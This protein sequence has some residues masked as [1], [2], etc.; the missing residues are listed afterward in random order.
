MSLK[1]YLNLNNKKTRKV[2][3]VSMLSAMAALNTGFTNVYL[4]SEL[5]Q[6]TIVAD[7]ETVTLHTNR[8]SPH[9][10]L[11]RAGVKLSAGDEYELNK[12]DNQNV[13]INVYRAVPV[14]IEYQG[15]KKEVLTS[16]QTVEEA[17]QEAGYDLETIEAAPGLDTKIRANLN[18][19]I[20]DSA[21]KLEAL[22]LE[23]EEQAR[24]IETSR[25]MTRYS[26]VMEMEATAY[27]PT[28][29]GGNGITA[30]GLPAQYGVVAVDT[31]VIP[32]GTRLYIPGY[33][34]AIAA[35]TGGAIYGD[36]IDLCME[37]YGEAMQFGR[38]DVTVYVLD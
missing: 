6:V 36:R 14:T 10:L 19:T 34:E 37:S 27:L 2:V 11:A 30:S 22:R 16:K 7:G 23:R 17:L 4:P 20:Q 29:G 31:D 32:L 26:A 38:R 13:K 12:L 9:L 18:I 28:D 5:H 35:D 15:Q 25:G 8:T 1:R 24:Q 33:G 3:L 21:E